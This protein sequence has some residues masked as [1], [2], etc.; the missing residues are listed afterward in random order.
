MDVTTLFDITYGLYVISSK[1]AK[2][3][4]G[5]IANAVI[6]VTAEP[7]Q[8]L[9]SLSQ[10]NLTHDFIKESRVFSV[11][12]LETDT[13]L[14]FIG[15]F[16]FRSGRELN[17]FEDIEYKTSANGTPYVTEYSLG[18]LECQVSDSIDAG[19]HTIFIGKVVEAEKLKQGQPLTYAQYHDIKKGKTP[20]NAPT[21][22]HDKTK[23]KTTNNK[24]ENSKMKS[25]RCTVC[26]YVY[27]PEQGDPDNGVEPETAFED[28]PD[29]WVCPVCGAPKDQ[30]EPV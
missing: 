15:K 25:Y 10:N 4:N 19:T 17:K 29:D 20:K 7:P 3:F 5:Q 23:E 27:E 13:P 24:K 18:H 9:V 2:K 21:Y 22:V 28:I 8:I 30:F 14:S 11:S 16:G 26:G 1:K 6:Q 12:I